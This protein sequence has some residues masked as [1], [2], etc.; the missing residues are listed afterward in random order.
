MVSGQPTTGNKEPQESVQGNRCS[1]LLCVRRD[2]SEPRVDTV[3]QLWSNLVALLAAFA[4]LDAV[5]VSAQAQARVVHLPTGGADVAKSVSTDATDR[6]RLEAAF[7]SNLIRWDLV[8][9][10]PFAATGRI[11]LEQSLTE[12]S[13]ISNSYDVSCWRDFKGRR[14]AEYSIESPNSNRTQRMVTVWDPVNRTILNWTDG[15]HTDYVVV[16]N[17]VPP[18]IKFQ[19]AIGETPHNQPPKGD[20]K[21][22]HREK[23][24]ASIIGRLHV[25]GVR[26]TWIIPD[27]DT[28]NDHEITL[29]SETWISP[30]LKIIV[31]QVTNDP[32]FGK[33]ITELT[34]VDRSNPDPALFH[35]PEGFTVEDLTS[36][37]LTF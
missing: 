29:T 1:L 18:T 34:N 28:V 27:V 3:R 36:Q 20:Y 14:R 17:R 7:T 30:E 35:P 19:D 12:S 32:R 11:V 13:T 2:R 9:G 5:V 33:V 24:P 22:V 6:A 4:A 26:K 16:L 8:K 21:N 37:H 31:R 23:L 10:L 25:V 15:D